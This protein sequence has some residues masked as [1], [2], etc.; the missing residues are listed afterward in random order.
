MV[1]TVVVKEKVKSVI[2]SLTVGGVLMPIRIVFEP[3]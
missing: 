1:W 3:V 2:L